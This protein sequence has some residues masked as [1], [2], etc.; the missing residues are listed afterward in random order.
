MSAESTAEKNGAPPAVDH[1]DDDDQSLS[2]SRLYTLYFIRHAEALHNQ[3]EKQAQSDAL[4][5]AVSQGHDANSSHAKQ[6]QEEARRAILENDTIQDPPLS[7]LGREEARNAKRTL[8]KL[9]DQ[10]GLPKVEE[11]WVSPLQRTLQTADTIFPDSSECKPVIRIK[12][13][14]EERH[15]GMACDTHTPLDK[16][17]QRHTYNRFAISSLVLDVEDDILLNA[18]DS[19]DSVEK[20]ANGE[21]ATKCSGDDVIWEN[22]T[23]AASAPMDRQELLRSTKS[24]D[25]TQSSSS[26]A[27]EDEVEDKS[28]LRERTKRLFNMLADTDSETI[29][30][31]GHKG[32]LRE[33]ERGPL[34]I[35][36]A[37]LFKNCEVR[38]YRLQLDI[39][40]RSIDGAKVMDLGGE[41]S[42][43]G[44]GLVGTFDGLSY[45]DSNS[46]DRDSVRSTRS[47]GSAS[48]PVIKRVERVASSV[49]DV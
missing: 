14:L 40:D 8:D 15:T 3:L 48:V 38:V 37:E 47:T 7:E 23:V 22:K 5:L 35:A 32:Y 12:R 9:I 21:M 17:R 2:T 33:L 18:C 42:R 49:G 25:R 19:T 26:K 43:A 13:G 29:C 27:N 34:G 39:L 41:V 44:S 11:V 30:L 4:N 6:V 28:M 46:G 20:I 24:N 16:I 36:E 1:D 45:V 31:I 10:Y